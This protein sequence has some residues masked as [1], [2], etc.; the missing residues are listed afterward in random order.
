MP[1]RITDEDLSIAGGRSRHEVFQRAESH[2]PPAAIESA[3]VADRGVA[4]LASHLEGMAATQNRKII[5]VFQDVVRTI[6]L[7]EAGA[8]TDTTGEVRQSDVREATVRLRCAVAEGNAIVRRASRAGTVRSFKELI[9]PVKAK[10]QSVDYRR[11]LRVVPLQAKKMDPCIVVRPPV[12]L[13]D[14]LVVHNQTAM[15]SNVV[16]SIQRV[17]LAGMQVNLGETAVHV[18]FGVQASG[19][20]CAGCA[21][22]VHSTREHVGQIKNRV[23]R[24]AIAAR[25]ES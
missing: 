11:A 3:P 8:A 15:R 25:I 21:V 14:R 1:A 24:C 19:Y 13:G 20:V 16:L 4:V 23:S 10:P 2:L 22:D 17:L 5:D 12:W 6:V 18:I 7:G 9:K